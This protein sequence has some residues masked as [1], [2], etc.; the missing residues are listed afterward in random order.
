MKQEQNSIRCSIF[1][2]DTVIVTEA[3]LQYTKSIYKVRLLDFLCHA[4]ISMWKHNP[5]R[6]NII[7]KIMQRCII[8]WCK[9]QNSLPVLK[10]RSLVFS[11]SQCN[12]MI[13]KHLNY[14][15]IIMACIATLHKNHSIIQLIMAIHFQ[16]LLFN[17][18]CQ[19]PL[20]LN[21]MYQA[22]H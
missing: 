21:A 3:P 16:Q 18:Y 20:K 14:Q 22:K 19:V 12:L 4:L 13:P 17:C 5:F 8:A 15:V 6:V 10:V 2:D 11:I 9:I 7:P 1:S